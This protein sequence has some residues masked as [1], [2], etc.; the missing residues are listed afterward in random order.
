[1]NILAWLPVL[2]AGLTPFAYVLLTPQPKE[3]DPS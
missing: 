3:G 2:L 1:M